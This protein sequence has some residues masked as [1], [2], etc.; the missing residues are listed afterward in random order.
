M[1]KRTVFS[2]P[3]F[4]LRRSLRLLIPL[5]AILCS[6]TGL[7]MST[8]TAYA[9]HHLTVVI[10]GLGSASSANV[11]FKGSQLGDCITEPNGRVAGL[12]T[13]AAE[14]SV[15]FYSTSNCSGVRL[16]SYRYQIRYP[17]EVVCNSNTNCF[18]TILTSA[19]NKPNDAV[20]TVWFRGLGNSQSANVLFEGQRRG[21]CYTNSH[22]V[23]F[24]LVG[25]GMLS[26]DFYSSQDCSGPRTHFY[27]YAIQQG[28]N[29]AFVTCYSD[30][31][32][33]C[34]GFGC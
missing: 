7:L 15:D 9:A 4:S 25:N 19:S 30:T 12:L 32:C 13:G 1:A 34:S 14:L 31:A 2:Q 27:R 29:G 16:Q 17:S 21:S 10:N 23:S 24:P 11:L 3:I 6:T 28:S 8:F 26:V 18:L 5:V 33:Q 20:A 22:E